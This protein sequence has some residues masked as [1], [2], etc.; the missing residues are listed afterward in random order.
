MT[1]TRDVTRQRLLIPL[2]AG[3]RVMAGVLISLALPMY[4][5]EEPTE[6]EEI[7]GPGAGPT[8]IVSDMGYRPRSWLP[9]KITIAG[10]GIVAALAVLLRPQ[11]RTAAIGPLIGFAVLAA[12][13]FVLYRD[14]G[15]L[16]R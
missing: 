1:D 3:V 5:C 4:A 7:E 6:Y 8:C 15:W 10:A 11:R 9:T 14:G 12:A 16:D 2:V 13:W